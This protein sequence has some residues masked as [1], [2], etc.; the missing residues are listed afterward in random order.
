M[1]WESDSDW[2]GDTEPE[3]WESLPTPRT[4]DERMAW[5]DQKRANAEAKRRANE[6][7][8]AEHQLG[9]PMSNQQGASSGLEY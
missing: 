2:E 5:N 9:G 4:Y 3:P 8:S 6:I 1:T 7:R